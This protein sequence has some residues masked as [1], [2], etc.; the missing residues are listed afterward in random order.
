MVCKDLPYRCKSSYDLVQ[1]LRKLGPIPTGAYLFT[2]DAVSMYTNIDTPHALQTIKEYLRTRPLDGVDLD[3]F[4]LGLS[5]VMKHNVFRFGDFI[6]VQTSG[7]SMGTPPAPMYATL[8]FGCAE[9]RFLPLFPECHFYRRL[10]DD[11]FGIWVPDPSDHINRQTARWRLFQ[12]YFNNA[13]KLKWIF[14]TPST[15]VDFL[16]LTI[17]LCDDGR[18]NTRVFEK[19]L[20][21]HLYLPSHSCHPAGVLK[22]LIHGMMLRFFRLSS[23]QKTAEADMRRLLVRL[24]ARG[25]SPRLLNSVMYGAANKILGTTHA[26]KK[27]QEPALFIHLPFHPCDPSSRLIQKAFDETMGNPKGEPPLASLR[28]RQ[29]AQLGVRRLTVA[30]SRPPNLGNLLSIRKLQGHK[31]TPASHISE[32]VTPPTNP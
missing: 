14:S 5:A 28:N 22:G 13:C 27:H 32:D 15:S 7:T 2:C 18:I 17:T 31:A 26:P 29:G 12:T 6:L 19:A 30:Y 20:N 4:M 10:I 25:Y 24:V 1:D 3:D 21:L 16:D 11:G 9:Q 23:D 8:Y